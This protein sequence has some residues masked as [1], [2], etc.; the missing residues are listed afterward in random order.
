MK[1]YKME[2]ALKKL[3]ELG[4]KM[5]D[6]NDTAM[7]FL[8]KKG[9]LIHRVIFQGKDPDKFYDERWRYN[10]FGEIIKYSISRATKV[11][12]KKAI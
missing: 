11:G 6:E 1:G 12:G 3:T 4:Y 8:E 9:A 5:I 7:F 2:I 10:E